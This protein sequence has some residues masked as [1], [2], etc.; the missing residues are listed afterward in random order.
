M[1]V[2]QAMHAILHLLAERWWS[3]DAGAE[4]ESLKA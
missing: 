1:I 4:L 2:Q 3:G